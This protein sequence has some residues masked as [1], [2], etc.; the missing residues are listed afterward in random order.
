MLSGQCEIVKNMSIKLTHT[1]N[2]LRFHLFPANHI[3]EE[4]LQVNKPKYQ[5]IMN[6]EMKKTTRT[7]QEPQLSLIIP[8]MKNHIISQFYTINFSVT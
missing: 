8:M 1:H 5:L 4:L 6:E 7:F 2:T 3:S